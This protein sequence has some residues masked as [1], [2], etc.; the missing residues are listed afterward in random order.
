MTFKNHILMFF[1]AG[2]PD[3]NPLSE[4]FDAD[5]AIAVI[6]TS[7][8][9]TSF[10]KPACVAEPNLPS[11]TNRVCTLAGWGVTEDYAVSLQDPRKVTVP[12]ASNAECLASDPDFGRILS[13]RTF[14]AGWFLSLIIFKIF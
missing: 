11:L 9:Y 2:H 7:I 3:W 10:I 5:I 14:C 1:Y 13:S 4:A 12:I 6:S 8:E